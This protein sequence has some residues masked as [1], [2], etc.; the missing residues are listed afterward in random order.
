MVVSGSC[1]LTC[2]LWDLEELSYITQLTGHT[3]SI[4]ALAIND[5]TVSL[6]HS[7]RKGG[8]FQL[9]ARTSSF[10]TLCFCEILV[11]SQCCFHARVKLL[12]ARGLSS[13]C[14]P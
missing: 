1:D 2:I 14:G 8:V 7:V 12:H 10:S 11:S 13:T 4:S 3:N 6:S 5:L 9:T